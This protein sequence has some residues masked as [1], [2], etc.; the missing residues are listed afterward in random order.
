M[1][2]PVVVAGAGPVGLMLAAELALAGVPALVLERQTGAGEE[3][4][5]MAINSA[6]VELLAQRG[7]M[8]G[9]LGDGMEFPRAHFAHIWLDPATLAGAHPYTFLVPH[10]RVRQRLEEHATKAGARVRRG[11]EVVGLRQDAGGVELDVR[12]GGGTEVIR[13][14]YVVGCDGAHSAVRDLAGIGFP[15]ADEVFHGLVGDL[16]VEPGDPLCD[17]LGVHQHDDGFFTVGPVSQSVLRVTTGEFDAAPDDPAAPVTRAEL[18]AHVRRLT[19]AELAT[20]GAP[21][22]LSRWTAATRQA[23]RYRQG[24]VFLAGDAAHVHF[25]LGGQALSTGIED[26]V[27]LGWKLAARVRGRARDELLDTYHQERHPV[28]ARACATTRAQMA[29]LRP[30][31]GTGPLRQLLTELVRLGEVNDH[32]V[33]LVGGL[34]IRYP[35]LAGEDGHALVGR[36]LPR[37]E[38][39]TG[40]GPVTVGELLHSG[41]GVL[42]DLSPGGGLREPVAGRCEWIDVVAAEPVEGLPEGVLLRPD[43][44]V[45]WAG[46]ASDRAGLTAAAARWFGPECD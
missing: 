27:D 36:R 15:G 37:T 39:V 30:G 22:W 31:G 29:L 45:A 28:G 34:D 7:I 8:D 11:A 44:R 13:A 20:R 4:P 33:A 26:A 38:L 21:R 43:G 14:A 35:S 25:P 16:D 2:H 23:E 19:G 6:V 42:L 17:Q 41:H 3:A 5:G 9:L 12:Q 24:R 40:R 46:A 10:Q 18:A 1:N 32:L